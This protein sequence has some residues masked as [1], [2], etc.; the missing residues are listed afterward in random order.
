MVFLFEGRITLQHAYMTYIIL[1]GHEM[2]AG[3]S[4]SCSPNSL[5]VGITF[6][7]F[8]GKNVTNPYLERVVDTNTID[9]SVAVKFSI[10]RIDS[11]GPK[12]LAL[13]NSLLKL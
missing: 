10:R 13:S 4:S 9:I 5:T 12:I 8:D 7:N 1:T 3:Q 2:T 6:N 11:R